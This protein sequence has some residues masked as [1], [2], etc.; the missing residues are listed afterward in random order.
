M[1]SEAL[2]LDLRP[3]GPYMALLASNWGLSLQ[4]TGLGPV[5]C[6]Y[7]ETRLWLWGAQALSLPGPLFPPLGSGIMRVYRG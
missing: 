4:G 2:E 6:H 3:Q 7:G 5:V 1:E